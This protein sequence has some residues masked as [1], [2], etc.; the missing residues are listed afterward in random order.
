MRIRHSRAQISA[1][2]PVALRYLSRPARV[3]LAAVPS[4]NRFRAGPP[5][6]IRPRID[7]V[8]LM[9]ALYQQ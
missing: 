4:R 9:L 7:S 5:R 1:D 8:K 6:D 3:R 2:F